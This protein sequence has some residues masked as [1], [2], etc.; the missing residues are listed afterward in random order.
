MPMPIDAERLRE[1]VAELVSRPGHEKVRALLHYLLVDGLG[2]RSSEIDFERPAPEVHGQM[3]A[4][5]GRTVIEIKSDLR[6]EQADAKK[7]LL[8]YLR[9]REDATGKRYI[10]MATDGQK[11]LSY[12]R[13][14]DS[15]RH[16]DTF[17]PALGDPRQ[18]LLWLSGT[19]AVSEEIDPTPDS[20][21]AHL[22]RGSHAWFRARN[23]LERMWEEACGRAD[24]RLKRDLWARR[25]E[26]VYGTDVGQDDLF[27]QHTY[28]VVVAKAVAAQVVGLG[29]PDPDDLLSGAAFKAA[30]IQGVVEADF[31]DWLLDA[32]GGWDLVQA[33]AGEVGRF[34]LR[35][36]ETDVLKGLYESLIDPEQRHDLGEYYTPDWLASWIVEKVV[37][38]PL[39][40][41]VLDPA[42]GSG[43]FLF[44]AVRRV[45]RAADTAGIPN[46]DA[47]DLCTEKVLGIDVHP[48]AAQIA[49]VT[50]LLAIGE[51]RLRGNRGAVAIP[52]YLGDSLQWDT[53]GFL[54]EQDVLIE[55]PG[56]KEV[57]HIPH[58][59]ASVPALFDGVIAQMLRLSEAGAEADAF[60]EWLRRNHELASYEVSILRGTYELLHKLEQEGRDSV[61]GFVARNQVRPVWLSQPDQR[62]DVVVGNPPW[63]AYRFM[64][65]EIKTRFKEECYNRGLWVGGKVATHQDLSGY[66]FAR[67]VELYLNDTGRIAFVMP[68]GTMSYGQYKGFRRGVFGKR[69]GRDFEQIYATVNI[70]DAWAFDDN[71]Q[72]LFP[73]PSCVLFAKRAARKGSPLPRQIA[74]YRGVLPDRDTN[75]DEAR[76][77]L[78][79]AAQDWPEMTEGP[80]GSSHYRDAFH[81]GATLVPRMLSVVEEIP[82]GR[83]GQNQAAPNV[84]SRRTT[85]EN[86]PWRDLPSL[87]GNVEQEFLRPLYLG[88]SIAPFRVLQLMRGVVPWDRRSRNLLDAS[89]AQ[90][91][92]HSHLAEWLRRS[93]ELWAEHR[94]GEMTLTEQLDYYGKLT[95]QFPLSR[96]RVV[97]AKS[98]K[99]PAAALIRGSRAIIDHT[100]YWAE[101]ESEAEGRYLCAVFNSDTARVGVADRQVKGQWGPRHFDKLMLDQI[102]QFSEEQTLHRRLA[103][104]AERAEQVARQVKVDESTYFVTA[105]KRIRRALQ[106]DGVAAEIEQLVTDLLL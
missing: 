28:L 50:Y 91:E 67:C 75:A 79:V 103:A 21:T 36:V 52:V 27:F 7:Q 92:G 24:I 96:L 5:L 3:D 90:R 77:Y 6:R 60:T 62:P 87:S 34:R 83:L 11:F 35:D 47:L 13:I 65:S 44:H 17:E 55:V 58:A 40:L 57:L 2:A 80:T 61:W 95:S 33:I 71:V 59:V 72:P 74:S 64:S 9:E 51:E 45:L 15:L 93:E 86:P 63:L 81:Q 32:S 16:L 30:A 18:T 38:R 49:R 23:R 25:L 41:R 98:G 106:D 4:L 99:V 12:E 97:Y 66:F 29:Q 89:T 31:F 85:L 82:G 56:I 14:D 43:T 78:T 53:Q 26:F 104:A 8:R 42:C 101:P 73:V 84:Q 10:G 20:V 88:E 102:P 37:D 94:R 105:R 69:K 19:V 46:A 54:A 70:V 76:S 39:E 22:G 48:V 1:T 68:Y 100:L